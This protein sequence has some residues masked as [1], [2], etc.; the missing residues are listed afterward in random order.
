MRDNNSC[1]VHADDHPDDIDRMN[2]E[3]VVLHDTRT[4]APSRDHPSLLSERP[5]FMA[6]CPM[7]QYHIDTELEITPT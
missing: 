3:D 2:G 4:Y 1:L 7:S 6:V 5:A